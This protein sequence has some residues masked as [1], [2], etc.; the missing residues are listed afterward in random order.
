MKFKL[1]SI[2][3]GCFVLASCGVEKQIL[4]E[5][6]IAE[7][8]GYDDAGED[9]I[10]GTVVVGVPQPGEEANLG[11]EVYEAI[12]HDINATR[13]QEN[14]KTP[15]PI[16]GGR[17]T[18]ILYGDELARRGLNEYVDT[19]RRDPMVG[20]DLYLA[21][22]DGKAEDVVRMEPKLVRT[23]GVQVKELIEQ[24]MRTNLTDVDLHKYL[25]A[26]H[27]RGIDPVMP[28]LEKE[29]DLIVVKGIALFKK[30]K[31]IGQYIPYDDGFLFKILSENFKLGSYEIKWKDNDY[32]N[33]N[34]VESRVDYHISD[35][36]RNPRV[37]VAVKTKANL[38][39][40]QGY[41]LNRAVDVNK[42]EA[43]AE[44]ILEKKLNE[45]VNM[46][47][48]YNIDP[49][50]LGDQAKSKTR[51]FDR[52]HWEAVYP[53]IPIDVDL[54]IEMIQTGISE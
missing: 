40:V 34:N 35:A 37:R 41:N 11:K 45:M 8:V 26:S 12:S 38:L 13:Q 31:Y 54:D 10:K 16:V 1:L 36:N 22:V 53:H 30:D 6:L 48:A 28:L 29:G 15:F 18:V 49:L 46:F 47:Q 50:A 25:Y 20:R 39:E 52:K 23:P 24:N 27:G 33:I 42:I 2:A 17:L 5:V 14:A 9:K 3:L 19:Y 44:R 51:N 21:I 7:I 43:K 32:T 4:E